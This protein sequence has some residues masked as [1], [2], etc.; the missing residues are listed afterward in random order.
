L[1]KVKEIG[2]RKI[3][4]QCKE[5]ITGKTSNKIKKRVRIKFVEIVTDGIIIN[6]F[7]KD[8]NCEFDDHEKMTNKNTS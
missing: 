8:R 5:V 6:G 1:R 3:T 4:K 7:N 2:W